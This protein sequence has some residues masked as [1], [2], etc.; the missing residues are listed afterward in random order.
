MFLF[1]TLIPFLYR[2]KFAVEKLH[3]PG[4]GKLLLSVEKYDKNYAES[5]ADSMKTHCCRKV[6]RHA[7]AVNARTI[8]YNII[9]YYIIL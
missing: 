7:S 2:E 5:E 1:V 6:Y 8:L 9:S 4:P 3:F